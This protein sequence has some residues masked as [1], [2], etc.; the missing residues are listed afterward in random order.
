MLSYDLL[1]GIASFLID[2]IVRFW[3]RFSWAILGMHYFSIF[4]FPESKFGIFG[5][6]ALVLSIRKSCLVLCCGG[7]A[8][9]ISRTP[10]CMAKVTP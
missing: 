9:E 3:A 4:F 8:H 5:W 7:G 6:S 2:G 1:T 10:F